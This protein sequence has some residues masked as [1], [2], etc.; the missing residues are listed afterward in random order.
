MSV[1][2]EGKQTTN[3]EDEMYDVARF[4]KAKKEDFD[5]GCGPTERADLDALRYERTRSPAG[6]EVRKALRMWVLRTARTSDATPIAKAD[7]VRLR[8]ALF[9]QT[10]N[11]EVWN[12]PDSQTDKRR[13]WWP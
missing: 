12:D 2:R 4:V 9:T 5:N 13:R 1:M 8:Y 7:V 11:K 10:T 3:L 6:D